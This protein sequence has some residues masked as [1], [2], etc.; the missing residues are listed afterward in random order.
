[1]R[2][3]LGKS[4]I[5]YFPFTLFQ[6]YI[7]RFQ[8]SMNYVIRGQIFT[9]IGYLI[10]DA[11][12]FYRI[13]ALDVFLER[14]PIAIFGDEIAMIISMQ[15]IHKFDDMVVLQLLH[16]R[17]FV[18]E[19]INVGNVHIF[20]FNNLYRK[21]LPFTALFCSTINSTAESTSDKISIV[22]RVFSN[23]LLTSIF[24]TSRL[25]S[26]ALLHINR[27]IGINKLQLFQILLLCFYH[28]DDFYYF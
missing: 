19:E 18:I 16:D 25:L 20:N 11:S 5:S 8:I 14:A 21:R 28:L 26:V 13:I 24:L 1:M 12:P 22:K 3:A 9:A 23:S 4:E 17:Y 7:C 15:N 27:T 2:N 10:N 6:K